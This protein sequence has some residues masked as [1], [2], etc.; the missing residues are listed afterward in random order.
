MNKVEQVGFN[1]DDGDALSRVMPEASIFVS[2]S[3]PEW[4]YDIHLDISSGEMSN[5]AE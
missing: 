3:T 5:R 1:F 2:Q 4:V